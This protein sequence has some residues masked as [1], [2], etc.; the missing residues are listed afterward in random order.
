MGVVVVIVENCLFFVSLVWWLLS[1]VMKGVG[2]MLCLL[3][4]L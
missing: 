2:R 4:E 1:E 3:S